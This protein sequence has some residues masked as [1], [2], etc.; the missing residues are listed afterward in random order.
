MVKIMIVTKKTDIPREIARAHDVSSKRTTTVKYL[1]VLR[2]GEGRVLTVAL[3]DLSR[4]V[5][6][7]TRIGGT[8]I[9]EYGERHHAE[10][11]A[12]LSERG[13]RRAEERK[14]GI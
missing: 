11:A 12:R 1:A 7:E 3:H 2:D 8:V 4:T 6:H 10:R 5:A 14:I 9:G 13:W